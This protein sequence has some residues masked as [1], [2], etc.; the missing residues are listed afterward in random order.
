MRQKE[1]RAASRTGQTDPTARR[2]QIRE[3]G[4][5]LV[6]DVRLALGVEDLEDIAEREWLEWTVL[7][8]R[9]PALPDRP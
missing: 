7:D 1:R 9:V 8:A 3:P 4:I 6:T 5:R 2:G